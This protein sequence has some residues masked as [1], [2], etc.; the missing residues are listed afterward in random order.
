MRPP[1][2]TLGAG[3]WLPETQGGGW[4]D[5]RFGLNLCLP[6][7]FTRG[8]ETNDSLLSLCSLAL[9]EELTLEVAGPGVALRLR[10]GLLVQGFV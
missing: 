5:Q 10:S 1:W 9:N 7:S 6:S 4:R 3:A 2:H 8:L